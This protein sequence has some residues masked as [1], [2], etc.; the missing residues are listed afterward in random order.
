MVQINVNSRILIQI[1]R[2]VLSMTVASFNLNSLLLSLNLTKRRSFTVL[3]IIDTTV[4][5]GVIAALHL[6]VSLTFI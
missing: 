3:R 4:K 6:G 2:C 1:I 5:V